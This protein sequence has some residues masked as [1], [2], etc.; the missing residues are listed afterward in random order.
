M[1]LSLL[2]ESLPVFLTQCNSMETKAIQL[3]PPGRFRPS[4]SA[5]NVN[6]AS[7]CQQM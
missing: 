3:S 4:Q 1:N 2:T 6:V 5:V 7:N